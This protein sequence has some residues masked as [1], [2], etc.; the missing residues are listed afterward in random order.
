MS[1]PLFVTEPILNAVP[2]VQPVVV[3]GIATKSFE[4]ESGKVITISAGVRGADFN[5]VLITIVQAADDNLTVNNIAGTDT[6]VISLAK[7]TGSKNSA[8]N[9]ET[10]L[11]LIT[12]TALSGI[13]LSSAVVSANAAYAAA[14]CVDVSPAITGV[15]LAGGWDAAA[16]SSEATTLCTA[17]TDTLVEGLAFCA[18]TNTTDAAM[19]ILLA[20][21]AAGHSSK[22]AAVTVPAASSGSWLNGEIRIDK[23][24][25]ATCALK[26]AHT[27]AVNAG[28]VFTTVPVDFLV[29]GGPVA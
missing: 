4:V 7:T 5:D 13:D 22:F 15:A 14:P 25:P 12:A 6:I 18:E 17:T 21:D 19:I 8:A 11:N 28:N 3:T 16:L 27:M 10:A 29:F 2:S 24:L 26:V 9:I 1:A 23:T 20:V